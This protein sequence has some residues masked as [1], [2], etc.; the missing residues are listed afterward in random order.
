MSGQ[1]QVSGKARC[2]VR[3]TPGS[4]IM[5]T[6]YPTYLADEDS[7]EIMRVPADRHDAGSS[8]RAKQCQRGQL[9]LL[10]GIVR[11]TIYI[12]GNELRHD[13]QVAAVE[14]AVSL[15]IG[16]GFGHMP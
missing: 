8:D 3:A 11:I 6:V 1:G 7:V 15:T 4:W 14:K 10:I 12:T 16:S 2:Q 5:V 13:G 9:R